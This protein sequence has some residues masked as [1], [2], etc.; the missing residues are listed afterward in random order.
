M[1]NNIT[2]VNTDKHINVSCLE[3]PYWNTVT[4]RL[5]MMYHGNCCF[6]HFCSLR[7]LHASFLLLPTSSYVS[8]VLMRHG[9]RLGR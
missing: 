8:A 6:H 1:L 9:K 7:C 2:G 5:A 3:G 4:A